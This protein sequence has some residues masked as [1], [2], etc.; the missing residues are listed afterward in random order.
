MPRVR[1]HLEAHIRKFP[2]GL[3][4]ARLV[5]LLDGYE[6]GSRSWQTAAAR[7]LAF[8]EGDGIAA[9]DAHHLARG[10][11]LGPE[12][13]IDFREALEGKDRLLDPDMPD[14]GPASD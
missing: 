3:D 9:V 6:Q 8:G 10:P 12:H 1:E 7:E 11:H 4:D 13:G 2:D 14:L 5:G